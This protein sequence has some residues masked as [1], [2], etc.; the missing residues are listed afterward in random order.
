[1]TAGM[2]QLGLDKV[3]LE[4]KA[5]LEK[6]QQNLETHVKE[7]KEAHAGWRRVV[8]I[9]MAANLEK[10]QAGGKV[11]VGVWEPKEPENHA[12]EY[13]RTISLLKASIDDTV[14]I[15]AQEFRWYSDDEWSWKGQH[16]E[17]YNMLTNYQG[18]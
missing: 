13:E 2:A 7:Y 14:V 1:M 8:I 17:E 4:K 12:R 3:R 10:A 18:D 9:K 11:V 6:M 16:V 5:L 15:T